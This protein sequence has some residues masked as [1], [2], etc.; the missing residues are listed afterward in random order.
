M[1]RLF[2]DAPEL[3]DEFKAFLPEAL[4]PSS[5]FGAGMVG[6]MPHPGAAS[7]PPVAWDHPEITSAPVEKAKAPSRRRK[8]VSDKEQLAPSTQ[9]QTKAS[10]S[11]VCVIDDLSCCSL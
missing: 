10:G 8:R 6:I 7:T 4:G 3:M 5:Q 2:K 1:S 9:T 11:R